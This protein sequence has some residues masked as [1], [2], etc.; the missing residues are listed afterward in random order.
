MHNLSYF[1]AGTKE[2]RSIVQSHVKT[3]L[4]NGSVKVITYYRPYK[5]S[6]Q[7]TTRSRCDRMERCGVVYSF[8]CPMDSCNELYYGHT[9]QHLSNR[10]KQHRYVTSSIAKH[11][12]NDHNMPVP[13]YETFKNCFDIIYSSTESIRIKIVEALKIKADRPFINVK[14]DVLNTLLKLF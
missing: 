1:S 13:A 4:P 5:L 10:V 14:Y 2:I 8:K 11:L 6:S 12:H 3:S 9:T 7:F